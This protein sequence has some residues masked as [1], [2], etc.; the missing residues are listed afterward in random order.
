MINSSRIILEIIVNANEIGSA[1]KTAA[2]V[3]YKE[4]VEYTGWNRIAISPSSWSTQLHFCIPTVLC[5]NQVAN[6]T[7]R[8]QQTYTLPP[9]T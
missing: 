3:V 5:H 9:P 7:T 4:L 8:M 2:Y 6:T 1:H